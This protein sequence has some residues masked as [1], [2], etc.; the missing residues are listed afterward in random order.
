MSHPAKLIQNTPPAYTTARGAAFCGDSI[1]LLNKLPDGS[2]N[3]VMTSPP[4]ALLR[5][6]EYGNKNQ[7][8]YLLWLSEFAKL[9]HK[10]L[11]DDGSFVLDLGGSYQRGTPARSLYNFKVLIH[12]CEELGFFLAQDF[13]WFNPSKLPSPIEWVN[14]RKIRANGC[15]NCL[16]LRRFFTL[17]D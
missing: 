3:L 11:K 2:I 9:V 5:E 16:R 8:D 7:E 15:L 13:Y 4:F 17:R 6:K 10:K 12:F 14:K 1:E